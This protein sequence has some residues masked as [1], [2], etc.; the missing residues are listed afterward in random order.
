L[1]RRSARQIAVSLPGRRYERAGRLLARAVEE[2]GATGEPVRDVLHREARALGAR[3]GADGAGEEVVG[4]LER[5]GFEP[6]REDGTVVLGNCPFHALA[7]EHT[8]TACGM[9]L[10]LLGGV[11]DG[12]RDTGYP[13]CP[14][15]AE[16]RRGARPAPRPAR[17]ARPRWRPYRGTACRLPC[18]AAPSLPG[19]GRPM[20]TRFEATVDI[21]R[22]IDEVFAYLADGGHDPEFSPRVQRIDKEPG[23]PTHVGTVFTSTV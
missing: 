7:R 9:N 8:Q 13:A 11:L 3:I 19:G 4:V 18:A 17:A 16:G 15:P 10:H 6:R 23:G 20:S 22:P 14:S 5:Y 2:S 12:L 1:Y 21:D